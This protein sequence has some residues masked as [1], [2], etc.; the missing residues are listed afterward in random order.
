ML[1][2]QVTGVMKF[3]SA[4]NYILSQETDQVAMEWVDGKVEKVGV[5]VADFPAVFFHIS[6][7]YLSWNTTDCVNRQ[8]QVI[9]SQLSRA[10]N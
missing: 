5:L 7:W 2:C 3:L 8:I 10:I 6:H 4:N 1:L 9:K